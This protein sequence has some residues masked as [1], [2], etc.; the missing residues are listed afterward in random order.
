[1]TAPVRRG[2]YSPTQ[3]STP[4]LLLVSP[5]CLTDGAARPIELQGGL[6]LWI[7]V[8]F[9]DPGQHFKR[10][11]VERVNQGSPG[12]SVVKNPPA[13]AGDSF[14]PWSGKT[15]HA[16]EQP[17]PWAPA[18]EPV[19]WGPGATATEACYSL[20]HATREATAVRSPHTAVREKPAQQRRH[21]SAKNK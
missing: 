3:T 7:T 5:S 18:T 14:D 8:L 11:F 17:R 2:S 16:V 21:A 6:A 10:M 1:M 20:C 15:P 9:R 4:S 12:S 13:I 19:L